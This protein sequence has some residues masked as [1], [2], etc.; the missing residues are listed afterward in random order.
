M[1]GQ[2]TGRIALAAAL[3]V[4]ALGGAGA[5]P[6]AIELALKNGRLPEKQRLIRVQQGDEVTLTWTTDRPYTLHVHG[7]ELEEKLT[8]GT[9]AV[10]RFTARA[11]GRFPLEIHGP[12]GEE[13]TVGYL[14]V[15]PR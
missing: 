5:E 7:Y 2:M 8:P 10:M 1:T 12:R 4:V 14:E 13:R 3:V 11:T 6:K 9:P 15:H